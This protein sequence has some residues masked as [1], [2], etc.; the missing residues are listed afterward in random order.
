[1]AFPVC[2]HALTAAG[3][4]RGLCALRR[5]GPQ[6]SKYGTSGSSGF[7]GFHD[8]ATSM[9]PGPRGGARGRK[10]RGPAA[11]EASGSGDSANSSGRSRGSLASSASN[12]A[13]GDL[14]DLHLPAEAADVRALNEAAPT[15]PPLLPSGMATL[16]EDAAV[17]QQVL[18]WPVVLLMPPKFYIYGRMQ[19]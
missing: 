13:L 1:M 18:V 16:P 8:S 19:T 2:W 14:G 17:A 5:F 12:G 3:H 11:K 4:Q 15:L 10:K 7:S 6:P 9:S